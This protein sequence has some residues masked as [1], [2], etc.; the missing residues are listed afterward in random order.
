M[1]DNSKQTNYSIEKSKT[2]KELS[3]RETLIKKYIARETISKGVNIGV[4]IFCIVLAI[5]NLNDD[6]LQVYSCPVNYFQD[7][8]VVL[9]EIKHESVDSVEKYLRGFIRQYLRS[10]YPKNSNEA[11]DMYLFAGN[12]STGGLRQKYLSMA[13][14]HKMIGKELDSGRY[15]DFFPAGPI[16]E[17]NSINISM[18]SEGVWS[19]EIEGYLNDKKGEKRDDRGAVTIK[20]T[21]EKGEAKLNGSYSGLYV[22]SFD[23]IAVKDQISGNE[24]KIN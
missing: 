21:V 22:S 19:V 8:P 12:H 7:A 18:K 10:I 14:D 15:T 13:K 2:L 24:E 23:I 17:K 6:E 4:I 20:L 5:Q 9:N 3:H 11:K 16:T 1:E